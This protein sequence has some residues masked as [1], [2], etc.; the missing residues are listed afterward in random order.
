MSEEIGQRAAN[1]MRNYAASIRPLARRNPWQGKA[2][3]ALD[4]MAGHVQGAMT[5]EQLEGQINQ[6]INAVATNNGITTNPM[7]LNVSTAL[8]HAG[9][10]NRADQGRVRITGVILCV[11]AAVG[12]VL[13]AWE[14]ERPPNEPSVMPSTRQ[15][16]PEVYK[17]T[18]ES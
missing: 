5:P 14:P 13:A 3:D 2:A 4:E 10:E 6:R 7:S 16:A 9:I 1:S 18:S 11:I 17:K 15:Q 12:A 8:R